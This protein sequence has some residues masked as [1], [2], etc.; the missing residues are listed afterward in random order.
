MV[1]ALNI[2]IVCL[3]MLLS[4]SLIACSAISGRE[5]AGQYI[6]DTTIT[7]RVKT[8]IVNDPIL[9]PFTISVETF[10]NEVQL[11]GF[12]DSVKESSRAESLARNTKGVKLVKNSLVVR[13]KKS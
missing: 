13:G 8:K 11:S 12:V 2:V 3:C 4:T 7:A 1:R 6:D 9:K 5:T 10:Q